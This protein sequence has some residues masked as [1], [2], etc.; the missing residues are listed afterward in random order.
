MSDYMNDWKDAGRS[1]PK[2]RK[3]QMRLFTQRG[4]ESYVIYA[5]DAAAAR[6]DQLEQALKD[7]GLPVPEV[8]EPRQVDAAKAMIDALEES[9]YETRD[10]D[11]FV[12]NQYGDAGRDAM[13]QHKAKIENQKAEAFKQRCA[14]WMHQLN[15]LTET[16]KLNLKDFA[17]P[18]GDLLKFFREINGQLQE[19]GKLEF[20]DETKRWGWWWVV[21]G[22][23]QAS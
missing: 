2:L 20:T 12:W 4:L 19:F 1:A 11:L 7:A 8:I 9:N 21:G 22:K 16:T 14:Q 10:V 5:L 15:A 18:A 3:L 23:D 17:D 13:A 6:L